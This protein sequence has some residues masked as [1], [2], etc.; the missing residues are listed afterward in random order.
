MSRHLHDPN[1]SGRSRS[2]HRRPG[3]LIVDEM[4]LVLVQM[5]L[6]FQRLGCDV[7]LASNGPEALATFKQNLSQVDLVIL[8]VKQVAEKRMNAEAET[9]PQADINWH[10][11]P[12]GHRDSYALFVTGQILSTRT[13]P[14]RFSDPVTK[15]A[16]VIVKE[17]GVLV[18]FDVMATTTMS[19]Q[20][21]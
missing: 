1:R 10:T 20:D 14:G 6:E 12:F 9:N 19:E 18:G 15:S 13:V 3:I 11:V 16:D 17:Y 7:W 2:C 4:A 5:K 21:R 8:E